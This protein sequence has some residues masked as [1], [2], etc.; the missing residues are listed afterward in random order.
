MEAILNVALPIFALI[1]L[2]YLSGLW[3]VLGEESAN[4]LNRYVFYF[5]LPPAMFIFTARADIE[6][7][8]NWSFMGAY[9]LA[10]VLTVATA[11]AVARLVF[12][13]DVP[14]GAFHAFMST[15]ANVGYMGIPFFLTA[16]GGERILPAIIAGLVGGI[17]S[18]IFIMTTL[19]VLQAQPGVGGALRRALWKLFARNPFFIA[20]VLGILFSWFALPVPEPLGNLLDMLALTAGPTALFALGLA[21]VGQPIMGDVTE[22]SWL[23]VLKLVVQ[24]AVTFLVV[25]HV[26]ELAPFWAMSAVLLAAMPCGSTAY[27]V[28]QQ[29]GV[30]IRLASA[31]VAV[32]TAGSILTLSALMAYYGIS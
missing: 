19:D 12:R 8:L 27:V 10:M 14:R 7:V 13:T 29:Y 16:F 25:T 2:G 18:M 11:Y 28:A 24:P 17:P 9:G 6:D 23:T 30:A 15:F 1:A 3:G 32:T 22:V 5:A 4:A 26:F 31:T 21:L 20:T